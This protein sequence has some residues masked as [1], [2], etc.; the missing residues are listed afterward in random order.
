M[1]CYHQILVS[2]LVLCFYVH[3]VYLQVGVKKH[4]YE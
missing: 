4:F 2:G 3:L 1:L